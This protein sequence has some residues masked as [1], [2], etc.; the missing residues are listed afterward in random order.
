MHLTSWLAAFMT[1]V[2]RQIAEESLS[3]PQV[4]GGG[5]GEG[6]Q[7]APGMPVVS[8]WR[9]REG[10]SSTSQFEIGAIRYF[11]RFLSKVPLLRSLSKCAC[12][13]DLLGI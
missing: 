12:Q 6:R 13:S 7:P 5:H 10:G 11:L 4:R 9:R 1:G 2:Y 8:R 3:G